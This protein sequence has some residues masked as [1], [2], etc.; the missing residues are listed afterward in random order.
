MCI[1]YIIIIIINLLYILYNTYTKYENAIINLFDYIPEYYIIHK[2]HRVFTGFD[3]KAEKVD[4]GPNPTQVD[5]SYGITP[6]GKLQLEVTYRRSVD[7][8][9]G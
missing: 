9:D 2:F 7:L 6:F 3:S 4:L 5:V 8:F 1:Y